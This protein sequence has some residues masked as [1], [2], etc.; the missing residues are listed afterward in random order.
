MTTDEVRDEVSLTNLDQPLFDDAGVTKR[1]LVDYLD[2]MRDRVVPALRGR[3]L[4]VVRVRA[5]QAPFMQ[6]NVPSYAPSWIRRVTL[7]AET[8]RREVSYAL[9]DDR[10]TLLWFANQR[11]VEYHPTLVRADDWEHPTH[12]VLDLD[13]PVA[14]DFPMVVRAAGLIRQA[15]D[16][17]GLSGAVKTSGAKGLHVFV[18]LEKGMAMADVAAATRALAAR[19]ERLDPALATTAFIREDREGK[20]F[21]DS[22]RAGGATVVAAYSP[23]VRPGATVSFPVAWAD[24]DRVTPADFTVRTA[25]ELAG[26]G[27]PWAELMPEPQRLPADLVEEGHTIPVARVQA[28]H[29]GKR[30]ARARRG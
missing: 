12:L 15:L 25:A 28:M 9:C 11:A 29:E 22:T 26:D 6:K 27:D 3:P 10:R 1:D 17:A 13:P 24:L 5:G 4:S 2:A 30:R 7:W 14:D 21:L 19:A 20:V 16:D 8:S 23:R 18:P